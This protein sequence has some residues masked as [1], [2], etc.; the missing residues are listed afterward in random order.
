[1]NDLLFFDSS[2]WLTMPFVRKE[3]LIESMGIIDIDVKSQPGV[4]KFVFTDEYGSEML[5]D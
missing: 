5:M 2:E 3:K 1:M 4:F